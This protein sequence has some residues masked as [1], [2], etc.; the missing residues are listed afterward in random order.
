MKRE[1]KAK[2]GVD[3]TNHI[4]AKIDGDSANYVVNFVIPLLRPDEAYSVHD[5]PISI[6][7]EDFA[8]DQLY[9]AVI[10]N[11]VNGGV[12]VFDGLNVIV[13]DVFTR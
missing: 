5:G 6:E 10:D 1:F 4:I 12:V 2:L 8:Y 13:K 9:N 11:H 7:P 3:A